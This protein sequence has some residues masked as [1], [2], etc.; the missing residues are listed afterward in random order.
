[1]W[2]TI[3][4]NLPRYRTYPRIV[5]ETGG[6]DFVFAHASADADALV[7][8]LVRGAFENQGQKCSAVSRAYVPESLWPAVRERLVDQVASLRVG[9]PAEDFG[10]FM[11]AVIDQSAFETIQRYVELAR[12]SPD[13]RILAGGECDASVGWFIEPTVVQV[14]DPRHRLMEEEI[15]GP[16]L[17]IF[18][19]R[20]GKEDETLAIC[21]Q[22]SPYALTGA[23]FARDRAFVER[24][25]RAL[26]DAAGNFYVNDKP[27]GAVV[28]QQPFGG[29][30]ASGTNDKAGSIWNLDPLGLAALHQGELRPG[31][32]LRVPAHVGEGLGHGT[33]LPRRPRPGHRERALARGEGSVPVHRNACETT[34]MPSLRSPPGSRRLRTDRQLVVADRTDELIL[35]RLDIPGSIFETLRRL[36]DRDISRAEIFHSRDAV[37]GCERPLEVQHYVFDRKPDA[38]VRQA[39]APAIPDALRRDVL[40]AL[41]CPG[42]VA[43]TAGAGG[44]PP[45]PL[46]QRRPVRGGGAA[47][48][49]G[50]DAAPPAPGPV[51]RGLLPRRRAAGGEGRRSRTK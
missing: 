48:R 49:G 47:A 39:G 19:Y 8:A 16:V 11:G 25:S 51:E 20:D 36:E 38:L 13:A 28:G 42:R 26:V 30:R 18:V 27:T 10:V 41:A 9:D 23:V 35:A 33:A 21:D 44:G 50:A 1:M 34:A 7:T 12:A 14:T 17:T 31:D 6:K 24:A 29:A 5:G 22:T 37:P 3:A 2:R 43:G 40:S 15:F 46:A 4:E 45:Q 32:A